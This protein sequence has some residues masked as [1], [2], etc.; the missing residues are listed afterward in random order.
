MIRIQSK[1]VSNERLE[2]DYW[3]IA[4]ESPRI[5][6]EVKPGQFINIRIGGNNGPLFRRPF[7][8]Y[9]RVMS[10]QGIEVVY[11]IVGRGT[12]SMTDLEQ[13]DTLDII[14][15][16]GHGFSWDR[17]TKT[18]I[19]VGGGMGSA[20]LFLLGEEISKAAGEK[21]GLELHILLG[22]ITRQDLVLERDF[23]K[24]HGT[25]L[26]STDDGSYGYH[27]VV[28]DL[29]REQFDRGNI[30]GG[31]VIYACGP[32]QMLKALVPLCR[33]WGVQAQVSVERRMMC[34]IG[35]CLACVCKVDKKSVL[36]RRDLES[37]H[38]QLVSDQEF[39]YGL[40]CKDGPVFHL[41][42]VVF[43]E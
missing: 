43:D 32:E 29:L 4:L 31:A 34:G 8:V 17:E 7:S 26:S 18:H 6:S 41:D 33:H 38:I 35:A 15:P 30:P 20:S 37:S 36:K 1:I 2:G 25:V 28:T 22:A 10:N 11:K 16:L 12:R 23:K 21:H 14:G 3:R 9:R 27:G 19:L 24:L 40:V 5:A 13:D 39:G 42:E